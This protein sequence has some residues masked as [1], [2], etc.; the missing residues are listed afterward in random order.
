MPKKFMKDAFYLYFEFV[1]KMLLPRSRK[2]IVTTA[3][4]LFLIECLSKIGEISLSAIMLE[5]MKKIMT[6]KDEKHD[7]LTYGYLL[8]KL[9]DYNEIQLG[10]KVKG[11]NMRTMLKLKLTKK[12][13]NKSTCLI[14]Q[15]VMNQ[16]Y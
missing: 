11:K 2:Q 13:K 4:D 3:S 9:F 1:N 15:S 5:H 16:N 8:N 7:H 14:V 12:L 10:N 6:S